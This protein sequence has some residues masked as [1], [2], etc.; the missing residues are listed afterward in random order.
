[1]LILM[2]SKAVADPIASYIIA[3]EG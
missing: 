3:A 1:M 2:E